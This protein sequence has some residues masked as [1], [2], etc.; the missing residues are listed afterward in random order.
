MKIYMPTFAR[1]A[2]LA[3]GLASAL[4]LASTASAQLL[5]YVTTAEDGS[6]ITFAPVVGAST[7]NGSSLSVNLDANAYW[8]GTTGQVALANFTSNSMDVNWQLE[9]NG[10]AMSLGTGTAGDTMAFVNGIDSGS[11]TFLLIGSFTS[12]TLGTLD[13]NTLNPFGINNW[14]SAIIDSPGLFS[15]SLLNASG[16]IVILTDASTNSYTTIGQWYNQASPA[17]VPEPSSYAVIAGIA[18]LMLAFTRRRRA[19]SSKS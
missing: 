18:M 1:T 3:V 10:G 4:S 7:S 16:D 13:P 6:V 19:V 17:A 11:G 12:V 14:T 2:L 15:P 9:P 8:G 5:L